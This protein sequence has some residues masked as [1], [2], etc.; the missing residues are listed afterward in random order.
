[1]WTGLHKEFL[2]L[3][4]ILALLIALYQ[5]SDEGLTFEM[6]ASEF[7]YRGQLTLTTQLKK[8]HAVPLHHSFLRN[9]SSC[10]VTKIYFSD[11]THKASRTL[12]RVSQKPTSFWNKFSLET[13]CGYLDLSSTF[14]SPLLNK[15]DINI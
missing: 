12:A 13:V 15:K 6:S 10:F 14:T 4:T 2:K 1:M 7:P 11:V 9:Y 3:Q 5:S 8:N